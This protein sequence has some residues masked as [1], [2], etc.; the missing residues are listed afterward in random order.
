MHKFTVEPREPGTQYQLAAKMFDACL[1]R[2]AESP[3]DMALK[4]KLKGILGDVA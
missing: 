1:R 4:T 3:A 2:T